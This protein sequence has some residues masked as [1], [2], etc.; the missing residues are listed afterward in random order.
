MI[1]LLACNIT[2]LGLHAFAL[3]CDPSARSAAETVNRLWVYPGPTDDIL[4]KLEKHVDAYY[5]D[6]ELEPRYETWLAGADREHFI[7]Q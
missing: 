2:A 4:E 5:L 6:K 1:S 3:L 7:K